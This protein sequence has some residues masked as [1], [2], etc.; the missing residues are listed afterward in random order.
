[1]KEKLQPL[2]SKAIELIIDRGIEWY[3]FE[4]M[5]EPSIK[6]YRAQAEVVIRNETF[7]NE[8]NHYIA[9]LV[10]FCTYETQDFNQLMNV[11]A[12]IVA[13]ESFRERLQN[14]ISI[15]QPHKED[16]DGILE[17]I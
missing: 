11:R 2:S 14:I 10:K 13:L 17:G 6:M 16:S 9:D 5:D 3:D 8:L 15:E 12:S 7:Q 4:Q 1:M